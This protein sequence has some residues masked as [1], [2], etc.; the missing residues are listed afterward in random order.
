M[1]QPVIEQLPSPNFKPG[2]GG[3]KP[4]AIVEHITAGLMPG[5]LSWL[6]NPKAKASSHYLIT[7]AGRIIQLV[8]DEDTAFAAGNVE[9]PGWQ[10][11]DGTN[12]NSYTL[13]IEH[14]ALANESL[15]EVQ[16]Q[17]T[18]WLH[19][20]LV[21]KWDIPI[22][23][24]HIIGHYRLDSVNRK[25]DPGPGF[26]WERLFNDL[27]AATNPAEME[28]KEVYIR[29]GKRRINGILAGNK[30]YAWVRELAPALGRGVEWYE[31]INAVVI[32]PATPPTERG[33]GTIIQVVNI[34][35][36]AMMLDDRAMAPVREFAEA[37]GF[38]VTW[39]EATNTVNIV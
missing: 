33:I 22:D 2:R 6:R 28:H 8:R 30:A 37:L 35:L 19:I 12:P 11:Y 18:L 7:K 15:T 31:D 32:P 4:I 9:S 20:L 38:K 21:E 27:K 10:L 39:N 17:A 25:N 26:P 5:T 3:R 1:V 13:N 34:T 36:P 29:V 16:Y 23:Q 24:E 14:E